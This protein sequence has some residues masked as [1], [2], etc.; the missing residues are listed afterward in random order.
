MNDTETA[1]DVAPLPTEADDADPQQPETEEVA[2]PLAQEVEEAPPLPAGATEEAA[3]AP[4][5]DS[6]VLMSSGAGD[7]PL[8]RQQRDEVLPVPISADEADPLRVRAVDSALAP[9]ETVTSRW[10]RLRQSGIAALFG[11]SLVGAAAGFISKA[12][13]DS[14]WVVFIGI[15]LAYFGT[16]F[17]IGTS[18]DFPSTPKPGKKPAKPYSLR[19]RRVWAGFG[20][21]GLGFALVTSVPVTTDI[22]PS[23]CYIAG[24]D[25][26]NPQ[27][28]TLRCGVGESVTVPLEPGRTSADLQGDLGNM[29][30]T[31]IAVSASTEGAKVIQLYTAVG[32]RTCTITRNMADSPELTAVTCEGP[33]TP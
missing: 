14:Q 18:N 27:S 4:E 7:G 12:T 17:A 13:L 16:I 10:S 11:M 5:P 26:V 30:I 9:Q 15:S 20:M 8:R 6:E 23:A 3:L 2:L 33:T 24:D 32:D 21:L 29:A 25:V 19:T 1:G 22:D 28:V 31:K